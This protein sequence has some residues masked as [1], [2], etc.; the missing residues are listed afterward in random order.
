MEHS[1]HGL[2]C[3]AE[4]SMGSYSED[5]V[6]DD[7]SCALLNDFGRLTAK[8]HEVFALVA[9]GRT[10]KEIAGRLNVTD[11][12]VNQRIEAVRS[13]AGSP[14][15]AE[16]AR[17]YRKYIASRSAKSTHDQ[18][19]LSQTNSPDA[20]AQ[21]YAFAAGHVQLSDAHLQSDPYRWI[22]PKAFAGPGAGLNRVVA[23]VVVAFG[24][25]A[26]AL[27]CLGVIQALDALL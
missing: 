23:M 27:L 8:Q 6:I 21:H 12:A 9:E 18:T 20:R 13:R 4:V 5:A 1:R 26:T 10:T 25:F 24:L 19:L 2:G 22:V 7:E 11:S 15:R 16:L 3:A 14:P 17:A